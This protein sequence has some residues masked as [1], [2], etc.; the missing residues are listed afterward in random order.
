VNPL[1]ASLGLQLSFLGYLAGA[2]L[3]VVAALWMIRSGDGARKDRIAGIWAAIITGVWCGLAAALEPEAPV[4]R[5]VEIGRNLSWIHLLFRLFAN[6]G[7]DETMGPVRP[8]I[9]VIAAVECIQLF[10]LALSVRFGEIAGVADLILQISSILRMLVAIGAMVLLHN[11]YAGA[12]SSA[13]EVLRWS[14][15]AAA[16]RR[17]M[18]SSPYAGCSQP[19][20][21][22]LWRWARIRQLL[23]IN[24]GPRERS[25][26]NRSHF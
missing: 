12:T 15:I 21:S 14:A 4:V 18:C 16:G 11:L 25:H 2:V 26:F 8:V 19:C 5:F 24:C 9:V 6:D 22:S 17:P 20:V 13:R 10:L 7:R 23:A 1:L 3:C